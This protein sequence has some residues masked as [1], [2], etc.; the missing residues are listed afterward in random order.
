MAT[1][2]ISFGEPNRTWEKYQLLQAPIFFNAAPTKYK[3]ILRENK[4][5]TI[6]GRDYY[7][8]PN[9][10]ALKIGDEAAKLAGL[11]PFEKINAYGMKKVGHALLNEQET[12]MRAMYI[13]ENRAAIDGEELNIGVN[14]FNSIDKSTAFGCSLFSYRYICGNGVIYGQ[15]EI[16]T[17]RRIH[18]SGFQQIIE[19]LKAK[20]LAVMERGIDILDAYNQM[21]QQELNEELAEKL[22]RSR[23]SKKVLPDYL[24]EEEAHLQDLTVWTT[25]N[26]I[27]E[28]IWHNRA[29]D[30]KTKTHQ[31]QVLHQVIPLEARQL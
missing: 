29:S 18:S 23:L 21:A 3:A 2:K 19:D 16:F 25:Y 26:D 4:L 14:V 8:F 13:L 28:L 22:K 7:L 10:E 17:I 5:V 9:E 1:A 24:K 27:T 6:T 15:E 20:I 31:F 12:Q 11:E 30:L